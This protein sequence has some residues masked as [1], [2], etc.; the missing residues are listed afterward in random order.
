MSDDEAFVTF[1]YK[2]VIEIHKLSVGVSYVRGHTFD[3]SRCG[4]G[5]GIQPTEPLVLGAICDEIKDVI[6][7]L[8]MLRME[9]NFSG[10]NRVDLRE[11]EPMSV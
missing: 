9:V 6:I 4:E 2:S 10:H 7:N 3:G 5:Y 1:S 11:G 8:F